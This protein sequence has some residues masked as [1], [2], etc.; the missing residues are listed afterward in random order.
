MKP[1][2]WLKPLS[3][4]TAALSSL[5]NNGAGLVSCSLPFCESL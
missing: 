3:A 4:H 5:G 2:P 1:P